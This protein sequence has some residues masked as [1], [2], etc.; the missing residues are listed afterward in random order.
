M[1]YIEQEIPKHK[2][3]KPS[4]VSKSEYKSKHKH[5]YV[6]AVCIMPSYYNKEMVNIISY[7]K[8]C[9]KIY[10]FH[11]PYE[12]TRMGTYRMLT[13]EEILEKYKDL[14][15]IKLDK[16]IFHYRNIPKEYLDHNEDESI[17]TEQETESIE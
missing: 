3:K 17:N 11:R 7:C 14:K 5:E 4:S 8:K 9:G 6:E 15:T 13:D 16:M 2:K 10:N 1:T 12:K